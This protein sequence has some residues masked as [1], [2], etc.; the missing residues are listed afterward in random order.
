MWGAR[1]KLPEYAELI[2]ER[3]LEFFYKAK[4]GHVFTDDKGGVIPLSHLEKLS[5]LTFL[6]NNLIRDLKSILE[7]GGGIY[8]R[9]L[10]EHLHIFAKVNL[11]RFDYYTYCGCQ[12]NN[13][14]LFDTIPRY[15]LI[16]VLKADLE[17]IKA[18]IVERGRGVESGIEDEYLDKL[19]GMYNHEDFIL[20]SEMFSDNVVCMDVS[21]MDVD[22]AFNGA[23]QIIDRLGKQ[24]NDV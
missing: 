7:V 9:T 15:D 16:I 18:R 8:D 3:V 19:N 24:T 22:E 5:Q 12:Y 11:C 13:F 4:G 17:V 14:T 20:D 6:Y 1:H 2:D 10:V 21:N 23:V